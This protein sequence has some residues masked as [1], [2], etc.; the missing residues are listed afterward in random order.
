MADLFV[1]WK[2]KVSL[3]RFFYQNLPF[4]LIGKIFNVSVVIFYSIFFVGCN[5]LNLIVQLFF[6]FSHCNVSWDLGFTRL[7]D[8]RMRVL[9]GFCL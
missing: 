6:G 8:A 3:I 7:L 1:S 2:K 9:D 5:W 4:S